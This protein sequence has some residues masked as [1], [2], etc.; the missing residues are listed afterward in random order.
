ME[1]VS[2]RVL[3]VIHGRETA[4]WACDAR[5]AVSMLHDPIVRI[6]AVPD[7][8]YP[9]F[10]S[11]TP[12]ARR[13]Y[14]RAV[15]YWR[16]QQRISMQATIDQILPFVPA[17]VEV[18]WLPRLKGRLRDAIANH[19]ATWPADAVLVDTPALLS[20]LKSGFLYGG[21]PGETTCALIVTANDTNHLEGANS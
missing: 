7:S 9:P 18:L 17:P 13:A 8:S 19:A 20:Q 2:P 16:E 3:I 14:F 5:R 21:P 10:T 1:R 15:A 4:R 11:V 6:L 12:F